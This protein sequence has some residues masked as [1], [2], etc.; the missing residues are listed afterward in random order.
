M[1]LKIKE[2]NFKK[3]INEAIAEK[4][5]VDY[6]NEVLR[7]YENYKNAFCSIFSDQKNTMGEVYL[8]R[9]NYLNKKNT[10]REIEILDI[11]TFYD[12]ACKIIDSMGWDDDHM[13]GFDL[14]EKRN[15]DPFFTGSS[16]SFFAPGWEDDPHPTFKTD[17]IRICDIDYGKLPK[18]IFTFDY[19]DNH[20]FEVIFKSTMEVKNKK[21]IKKMPK[22]IDTRGVAPEQY[23]EYQ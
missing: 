12:L 10:W 4:R 6:L 1:K 16:L 15:P 2:E 3:S 21:E 17:E 14:S 7:K 8:F 11:Q 9:V 20:R 22:V 5:H 13:H 18:L 19:G 23:P